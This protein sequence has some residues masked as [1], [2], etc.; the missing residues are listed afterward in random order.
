[1]VESLSERVSAVKSHTDLPVVVGFGIATPEQAAVAGEA[2]DGVVVGSA[3][4]KLF[5]DHRCEH[6]QQVVSTF[7]RQ[8]KESLSA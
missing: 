8:L 4:V 2:A 7:V 6:L 3:L 1:M 5:E